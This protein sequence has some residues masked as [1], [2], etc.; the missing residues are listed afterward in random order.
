MY[1]LCISK[2]ARYI[3]LA[4]VIKNRKGAPKVHQ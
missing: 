2:I 4:V 3:E 1:K